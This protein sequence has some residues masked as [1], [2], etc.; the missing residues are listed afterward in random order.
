MNFVYV[1]YS[2]DDIFI[3]V[4]GM[5]GAG[6]SNF[7]TQCKQ[8]PIIIASDGLSLCKISDSIPIVS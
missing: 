6:K 3:P 4:M 2:P 8:E 5:N 1:F 7:V